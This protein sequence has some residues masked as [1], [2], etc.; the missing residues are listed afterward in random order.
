MNRGPLE[1]ILAAHPDMDEWLKTLFTNS[2][3]QQK[4]WI[5]RDASA[6]A[7]S[8]NEMYFKSRIKSLKGF[9]YARDTL[10]TVQKDEHFYFAFDILDSDA[11]FGMR[12]ENGAYIN[13]REFIFYDVI[14]SLIQD[15]L[16]RS[17]NDLLINAE[18]HG[19]QGNSAEMK[20][21]LIFIRAFKADLA[22]QT[23]NHEECPVYV[24]KGEFGDCER[25]VID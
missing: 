24:I 22:G 16:E 9:E 25:W 14:Q 2:A 12:A 1:T 7:S 6:P 21:D 20:D 11:I 4:F 23:Q 13:L 15:T 8:S 18:Q 17:M 3:S 19:V 5:D 10:R